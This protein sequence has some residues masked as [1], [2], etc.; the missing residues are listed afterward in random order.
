MQSGSLTHK[1]NR[2]KTGER[3]QGKRNVFKDNGL[4]SSKTE[5]QHQVMDS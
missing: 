4:E 2:R 5:L 3:Q 1:Q